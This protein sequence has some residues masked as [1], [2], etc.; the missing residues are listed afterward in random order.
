M[1]SS[2]A[3][4]C[5][6]PTAA[7]GKSQKASEGARPAGRARRDRRDRGTAGPRARCPAGAAAMAAVPVLKLSGLL[8]RTVS[9]PMA[10]VMQREAVNS[11]L[12]RSSVASVGQA[13]HYATTYLNIVASGHRSIKIRPLP[14]E[15]ALA[16]GSEL[17]GEGFIFAVAGAI[18]SPAPPSPA[19]P[20]LRAAAPPPL[21]RSP[22]PRRDGRSSS[23]TGGA[24]QRRRG[25]RSG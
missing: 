16:L 2:I 1:H 22:L 17:V 3:A 19:G 20:R 10:K 5:L 7:L 13:S 18:V 25:Q 11:P 15:K 12:L 8:L 24:R 4:L 21:T 23:S 14:D 9:K 6:H